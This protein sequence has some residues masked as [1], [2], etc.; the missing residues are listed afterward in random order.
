MLS[1]KYLIFPK[2]VNNVSEEVNVPDVAES[3]VNK[4]AKVFS[5]VKAHV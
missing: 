3:P 2:A 5:V 1:I 4:V